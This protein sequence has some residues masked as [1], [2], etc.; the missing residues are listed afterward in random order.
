MCKITKRKLEAD[1]LGLNGEYFAVRAIL[2]IEKDSRFNRNGQA[3]VLFAVQGDI[4]E[5]EAMEGEAA[6][7]WIDENGGIYHSFANKNNGTL[8]PAISFISEH[9]VRTDEYY[10]IGKMYRENKPSRIMYDIDGSV[11]A[12]YYTNKDGV[13][14]RDNA[15]SLIL[16]KNNA[17]IGH[18]N[19]TNGVLQKSVLYIA[20]G[21][22]ESIHEDGAW[23]KT[24]RIVAGKTEILHDKGVI[25]EPETD[26]LKAA[27]QIFNGQT[28]GTEDIS[29][30]NAPVNSDIVDLNDLELAL[31]LAVSNAKTT[32]AG[33]I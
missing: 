24:V 32:S 7:M 19:Y 14:H 17:A 11:G 3:T 5:F 9:K 15:P 27:M 16:Y 6:L 18:E 12:E 31:T 33:L 29:P 20:G 22:E 8:I 4:D 1:E 21:S 28:A 2:D 26:K 25:S 13:L 10:N 30:K 23:A